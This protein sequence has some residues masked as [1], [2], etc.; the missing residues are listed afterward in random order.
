[1]GDGN[2]QGHSPIS[3]FQP[4][5]NHSHYWQLYFL[6]K[7]ITA[8]SIKISQISLELNGMLNILSCE[9]Y[10]H[11]TNKEIIK[12]WSMFIVLSCISVSL[13]PTHIT[14]LRQ[15]TVPAYVWQ[16]PEAQGRAVERRIWVVMLQM[17]YSQIWFARPL[18]DIQDSFGGN[19][20][21]PYL[22]QLH[23][24]VKRAQCKFSH[25]F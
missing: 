21:P 18:Q 17:A 16:W 25:F 11:I 12:E 10:F 19:T 8:N 6:K 3:I 1:M 7:F 14:L 5:H 24:K 4:L 2:L 13:R 15:L 20:H 9:V 22:H 23:L